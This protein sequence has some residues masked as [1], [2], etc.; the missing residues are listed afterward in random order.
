MLNTIRHALGRL[1][2]RIDGRLEHRRFE[3]LVTNAEEV[4]RQINVSNS[5]EP[6][7]T[8][9]AIHFKRGPTFEVVDGATAA[10]VFTEVFLEDHYPQRLIHGSKV[11]VDVGANIGLFSYYARM[12]APNA[13]I[14]AIEA[15]PRTFGVLC[16]NVRN[17]NVDCL[18]MAAA[19]HTGSLDFYSSETSGWSSA[20]QVLGAANVAPIKVDARPLSA[21][22]KSRNIHSLDF[23]KIDVEGAEYDILLG[24]KALWDIA[25][26]SLVVEVDERPRDERYKLHDM[27]LLLRERF[28]SVR[29]TKEH[30]LYPVFICS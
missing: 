26:K 14:I 5:A 4:I 16:R 13:S 24:D 21:E 22:L 18:N 20:F 8:L 7:N 17:L 28:H 9:P 12:H 19:S 30:S 10:H 1:K 11:I 29:K 15:D 2:Y 25:I 6:A 23:L 27:E 3:R